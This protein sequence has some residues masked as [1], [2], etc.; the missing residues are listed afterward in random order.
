[1]QWVFEEDWQLAQRLANGDQRAYRDFFDSYVPVLA[2]FVMRR[3][4]LDHAS[5]EDV[6]QNVLIRALRALPGYR[7]EAS[8]LTWLCQIC[9]SELADAR[10]KAGRRPVT[11]SMD[12]DQ[13]AAAVVLQLRSAGEFDTE[14]EAL[15]SDEATALRVLERL[16]ER[17]ASALEWKYGDDMSVE[18][19]AR[20]MGIS[21]TAAQSL[22]ARARDAFRELW[23]GGPAGSGA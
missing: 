18:Q 6:V 19:I 3:S 20:Q 17:Y 8:L 10:R 22:L 1:L 16:P 23:R 14:R 5:A 13:S 4:G 2:A 7:G 21:V 12:S 11:V 9:R 15:G